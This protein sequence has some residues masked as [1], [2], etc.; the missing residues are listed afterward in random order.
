MQSANGYEK[1]YEAIFGCAA[2]VNAVNCIYIHLRV[3]ENP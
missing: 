2:G 1:K 3:T